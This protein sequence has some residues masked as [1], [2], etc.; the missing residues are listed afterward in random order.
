ML[1]PDIKPSDTSLTAPT[2]LVTI[3]IPTS[4]R[5]N[6]VLPKTSTASN[7]LTKYRS[8]TVATVPSRSVL[9]PVLS[10]VLTHVR[11]RSSMASATSPFF[12][13]YR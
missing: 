3:S 1:G 6:N 13:Y 7:S 8:A 4:A 11:A 10:H 9:K 12:F 5:L 2:S